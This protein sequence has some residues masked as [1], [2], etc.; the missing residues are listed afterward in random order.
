MV[1]G[2]CTDVRS[3]GLGFHVA[4]VH[5]GIGRR[6]RTSGRGG[7]VTMHLGRLGELTQRTL[8]RLLPVRAVGAGAL[9]GTGG[10]VGVRVCTGLLLLSGG[11]LQGQPR[12][13][14]LLSVFRR[15]FHLC[16]L[17]RPPYPIAIPCSIRYVLPPHD[18]PLGMCCC[19]APGA[20]FDRHGSQLVGNRRGQ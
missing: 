16:M 13:G 7:L 12:W 11:N 3:G 15:L 14:A 20:E 10:G 18:F 4:C 5:S 2:R 9:T 19:A 6:T 17:P 1:S 8:L